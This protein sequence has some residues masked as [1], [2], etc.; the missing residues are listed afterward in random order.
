M[1]GR[2]LFLARVKWVAVAIFYASLCIAS[3]AV[4]YVA[5]P[6]ICGNHSQAAYCVNLGPVDVTSVKGM[7]LS[8]RTYTAYTLALDVLHVLGFWALGV[9]IFWKKSANRMVLF[10]SLTLMLLGASENHLVD[11]LIHNYPAWSL[12]VGIT[13]GVGWL[14]LYILFFIFPDGRFVPRWTRW[15]CAAGILYFLYLFFFSPGVSEFYFI[16]TIVVLGG[17]AI[18]AQVYRYIRVSGP[19]ERQQAKFVMVAGMVVVGW[20]LSRPIFESS[21]LPRFALAVDAIDCLSLLLVPVSIALAI[22]RYR[23]WDIDFFINRAMIYS[24]LTVVLGFV[25]FGGVTLLQGMFR[26]LIGEDSQLAVVAS[27][28]GIASLFEPLRRRVHGVIDR[29]FYRTKYDARKTLEAFSVKLRDETDLEALN[30][31]LVG[32]VRETM[33]PA[34]VSLWL[35]PDRGLKNSRK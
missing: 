5:Y 15:L 9:A 13:D 2:W 12:L 25:F 16:S 32:A 30:Y 22:L 24:T 7:G 35:R 3:I 8:L 23:L 31:D 19:I 21:L 14:L 17:G 10:V 11:T 27:T 33:Q 6:K 1:R 20:Q 28:L 29:L 34:H 4:T 26:G 18:I